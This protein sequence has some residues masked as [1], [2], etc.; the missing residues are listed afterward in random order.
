MYWLRA[1]STLDGA[2]CFYKKH[3]EEDA[4]AKGDDM[5]KSGTIASV[6]IATVAF[7]AAFTVTGGFV[8]DDHARAGTA[9]LARRFAFRAFVVSDTVAFVCSIVATCFQIYGSARQIP[10]GHR[11]VYNWLAAGLVPVGSQFMI[12]AFAFGFHLVLGSVNRWL[13]VFIY[14]LSLA[15]VLFCFP[16]IWAPLHLGL[17]KVVWR[18]AGWRGL[19]NIHKRPSSLSQLLFLFTRSFLFVNF[20][21]PLFV[22]LISATFVIAIVLSIALPNY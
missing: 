4:P 13:I 6:L 2:L 18:R 10:H 22:L 8:A 14:I 21:R 11:R 3:A 12:A 5:T 20:R 15:S 9:V 19:A 7:A 16:G 17:G 1:P